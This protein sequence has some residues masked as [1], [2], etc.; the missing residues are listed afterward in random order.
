MKVIINVIIIISCFFTLRHREMLLAV[1]IGSFMVLFVKC[2][3]CSAIHEQ[4]KMSLKA[5]RAHIRD[6][7]YL[8]A[9]VDHSIV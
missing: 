1:K 8:E 7:Y 9:Y 3:V 5:L 4:C 6:T 2:C